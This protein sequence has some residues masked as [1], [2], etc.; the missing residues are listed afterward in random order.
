MINPTVFEATERWREVGDVTE[1]PETRAYD[2]FLQHAAE[3]MAAVSPLPDLA[4]T[5][6][7]AG[8]SL[9][10][11]R[12]WFEDAHAL[13]C[14]VVEQQMMLLTDHLARRA[15][16]APPD[17]TIGQL[18]ALTRA[19]VEWFFDNPVGSRLL[20]SP[21]AMAV[22]SQHQ[23]RRYSSAIYDLAQ[24]MMERARDTGLIRAE[25]DI[26]QVMLTMR[27]LTLG[28]V[29]LQEMDHARLWGSHDDPRAALTRVMDS[30]FELAVGK[31][32]A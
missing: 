23:V 3:Q 27:A 24:S 5:A 16:A 20:L 2:R 10:E 32:G 31:P 15:C 22:L 18:R 14:T 17:D 7:E 4:V 12:V 8:V 11:A 6:Q 28:I 19:Y 21:A 26:P 9:E 13:S 25:V 29:V 30:Y 1:I